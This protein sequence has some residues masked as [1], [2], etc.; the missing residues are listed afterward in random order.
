[1]NSD[2]N[3]CALAE[4]LF[5]SLRG[6]QNLVYLTMST[7]LGGGVI[8]NGQLIQGLSDTAGEVG[9]YV[10]DPAG[11]VCPCGLRGCFEV[12]CGGLNVARRIQERIQ[13][14]NIKTSILEYAG[15]NPH[16]IDLK[17]FLQAVRTQDPFAL[18]TWK[19]FIERLAQGMG[20]I[21]MTLN[22]EVIVLGT[23]AIHAGNLLMEPLIKSLPKYVWKR[24]LDSC[25][26]V[27]ST[28]GSSIGDLSAMAVALCS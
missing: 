13:H 25:K 10:L 26:I 27:P 2:A 19:E 4:R 20:I 17:V 3:A 8:A 23:I 24:P 14:E 22:P 28:L 18:E 16:D 11:P 9:H 6:T 7:G 21:I 15:G 12:Y 1:M 5:G